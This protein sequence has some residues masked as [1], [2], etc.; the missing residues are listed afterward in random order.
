MKR[1]ALRR[2]GIT[3]QQIAVVM[4]LHG[5]AMAKHSKKLTTE[6]QEVTQLKKQLTN[7]QKA[8]VKLKATVRTNELAV[9]EVGQ[10]LSE[11]IQLQNESLD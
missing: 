2:L 11:F 1:E 6:Q 9:K 8:L 7:T 4:K 3:K 5:K 10:L